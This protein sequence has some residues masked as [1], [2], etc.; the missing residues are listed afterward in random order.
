MSL[1]R[2]VV[3]PYDR[4]KFEV[5]EDFSY[6]IELGVNEIIS[7]VVPKGYTTDGASIPRIFWSFYPPY[8]SEY[9]SACVLHDYLCSKAMHETSIKEAY[10]RADLCFY[11][12]LRLLNVNFVTCFIF[13]HLVDKFHKLKCYFKGWK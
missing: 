2:V 10:K 9:F 5:Y 12:H 1:K 7:G 3:K 8:K 6:Q 11:K 4:Y 13:Y